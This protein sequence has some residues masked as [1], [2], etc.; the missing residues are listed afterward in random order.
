MTEAMTDTLA[1]V[2]GARGFMGAHL[3]D[4]LAAQ[5]TRVI[6]FGRQA[7]PDQGKGPVLP[8]QAEAMAEALDRHGPPGCVYHLA[9]GPTVGHSIAHPLVDF[10]SNVATTARLF[11]F[12]RTHAAGTPVRLASSAA[13][14]GSGYDGPI[15][16]G[17]DLN[18]SSPYGHHKI[19]AERLA[20]S[21]AET[22]GLTVTVLRLFSIYG[23]GIQ[24][25]LLFELCTRLA[26]TTG[27]LG[28]GGTG[29]ELRDWC[30]VRDAVAAMIQAP[31]PDP[32]QIRT[33][34]IATGQ[35]TDIRTVAE[36]VV[37]AWG[38]G[39][40][41]TFSGQSRPGD[42]YSLVA[43][44]AS[45]PPGFAPRTGLTEGLAGFVAWYTSTQHGT[46][47]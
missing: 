38:D 13:V 43:D 39:R 18:P 15:A 29:A 9:G 28:L 20:A 42:P 40:E 12:L 34:N 23:P 3:V 35:G 46:G 10:E 19:M 32:G 25:Q 31:Q 30:H 11:D 27:P 2:T 7:A 22:Y 5:G 45:L 33:Y 41:I 44:P 8:L 4:H 21:Y 1:W 17:A 37:E 16:A 6:G 24:K 36:G 47:S 26:T 14:Y